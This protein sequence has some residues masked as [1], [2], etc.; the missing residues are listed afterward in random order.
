MLKH[1]WLQIFVSG[2]FHLAIFV[3]A[4]PLLKH[5]VKS[6]ESVT[7]SCQIEDNDAKYCSWI[8]KN[9]IIE[10]ESG[11][12]KLQELPWNSVVSE[13]SGCDLRI[14]NVHLDEHEG[15]WTCFTVEDSG[16]QSPHKNFL[17]SVISSSILEFQSH[18]RTVRNFHN[19][20]NTK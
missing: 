6:G 1:H 17:I 20:T 12:D 10:Y 13:Q 14:E 18:I 8:F 7:L 19:L 16:L 3:R 4:N 5:Y 9:E 2:F 15:V 11:G